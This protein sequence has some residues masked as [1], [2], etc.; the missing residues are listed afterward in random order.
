MNVHIPSWKE[1]HYPTGPLSESVVTTNICSCRWYYRTVLYPWINE[2]TCT[3]SPASST[4][5]AGNSMWSSRKQQYLQLPAF[6]AVLL[7]A[8]PIPFPPPSVW[9]QSLFTADAPQT[10]SYKQLCI[11]NNRGSEW[12]IAGYTLGMR[13]HK[14]IPG[15]W[16][17][18]QQ[19]QENR[20][21]HVFLAEFQLH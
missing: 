12:S 5:Q 17:F 8:S 6:S 7:H 1:S 3:G 19:W 2:E 21:E 11:Q 13:G 15:S 14:T 9:P 16:I 4:C 18:R 10:L 20:E